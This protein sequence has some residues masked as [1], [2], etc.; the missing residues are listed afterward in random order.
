MELL[1]SSM[2]M[3]IKLAPT[4]STTVL[5]G[6]TSNAYLGLYDAD[7]T[8]LSNGN[9]IVHTDSWNLNNDKFIGT[10]TFCDGQLGL[11]GNVD[12]TNSYIG[13]NDLGGYMPP[14]NRDFLVVD[15]ANCNV[16]F[17]YPLGQH[18]LCS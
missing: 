11:S 18:S 8:V 13:K 9:Y 5:K 14:Y 17:A 16:Y 4:A 6:P 2:V 1:Y 10:Y 15:S 7:I 12:S 3:M